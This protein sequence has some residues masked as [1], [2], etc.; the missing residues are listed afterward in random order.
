MFKLTDRNRD[1]YNWAGVAI[2]LNLSF[3]NIL[4]LME[5]FDD[6]SVPGHIKPNIALN[7]LI[8]DNALLTQLSP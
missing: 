2:E 6:E 1:I 7:M 3:D 5:L 8:V 4:K